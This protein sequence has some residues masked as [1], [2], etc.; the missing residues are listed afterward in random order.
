MGAPMALNLIKKGYE[1]HVYD[2]NK[3]ILQ[4]MKGQ[5]AVV[6][7]TASDLASKTDCVLTMLPT[8]SDVLRIYTG[9]NG[10]LKDM[11]PGTLLIDSS[12]VDPETSKILT[13]LV[14]EKR[15]PFI[16][17]PV[18]GGVKAAEGGTLTFMVGGDVKTIQRA[19]PI[20]ETMGSNVILCGPIGSGQIAKLC[21]N[22]LLGIS[23]IGLS[24]TLNL[25]IQLGLDPKILATVINTSSGRCWSSEVY[26]PVPGTMDSV[27]SSKD[28]APGFTSAMILKDLLLAEEV[29][30]RCKTPIALGKASANLYQELCRTEMA[31]KDF[32]IIY[33]Y[34]KRLRLV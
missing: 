14:T 34:I 25:G 20:L 26:N 10:I 3:D 18:S 9:D 21:N 29:A 7:E 5:G 22:M 31:R 16:D 6:S 15:L 24:E 11:K 2:L 17:A 32:S 8:G 23:M 19:R 30:K 12:T 27:P 28:Y 1:L 33:Q 13:P 4:K